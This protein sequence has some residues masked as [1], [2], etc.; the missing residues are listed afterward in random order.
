MQSECPSGKCSLKPKKDRQYAHLAE[1]SEDQGTSDSQDGFHA[2]IFTLESESQDLKISAAAV[3][4]PVRIEDAD[5]QMQV[6]TV[7]QHLS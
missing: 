7:Q 2:S 4:V 5:F 6:D 3:K 1:D